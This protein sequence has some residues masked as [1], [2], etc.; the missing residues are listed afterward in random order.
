MKRPVTAS[1][2]VS[3]VL[4]LRRVR[5]ESFWSPWISATSL[6]QANLIFGSA[7][8][9]SCIALEARRLSR[10][11]TMVTDLAKRERKVASSIAVSPPP[12]TAMSWSLKKNP[13]QVAHQETPRPESL[14]SFGSPSLRCWEPVVTITALARWTVPAVSVT[15][16]MSPLRSTATTSSGTSSA[17]KR[18]ACARMLSMRSGP[19]I[20]S[21]KPGK[22]STSVVFISAPPAVTAPSNTSG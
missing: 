3:P 5:P 1:A 20:P 16:L 10:R 6:S 12:T 9:R 11:W 18:S 14:S 7:K 8:A 19:T 21:R 17:P 2:E 22:F 4:V 13:S 15:V